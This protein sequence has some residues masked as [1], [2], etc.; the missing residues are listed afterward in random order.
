MKKAQMAKHHARIVARAWRDEAFR[1]KLL[2]KP[3]A[4]LKAVGIEVPKGM[5]IRFHQESDS[6]YHIVL[7]AKPAK[8]VKAKKRAATA[9]MTCVPI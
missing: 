9:N 2:S 6:A 7:P 5:R 4:A 8:G 1:K 3:H